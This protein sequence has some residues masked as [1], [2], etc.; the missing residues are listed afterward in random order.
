VSA[1][2]CGHEHKHYEADE[3]GQSAFGRP[4]RG[5]G[6]GQNCP[7]DKK[8][9]KGGEGGGPGEGGAGFTEGHGSG[10]SLRVEQALK[11]D[12][13]QSGGGELRADE[14][15]QPREQV[16]VGWGDGGG[17]HARITFLVRPD[18]F[19]RALGFLLV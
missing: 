15:H 16:A 11:P 18:L 2:G 7:G 12:S 14:E 5:E 19:T 13:K 8:A 1:N 6:A 4:G 3:D 17:V 9:A 10:E